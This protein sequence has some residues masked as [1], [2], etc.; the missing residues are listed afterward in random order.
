MASQE[1]KELS[2]E[3][4]KSELNAAEKIEKL[5]NN[6]SVEEI[7]DAMSMV[8]EDMMDNVESESRKEKVFL[9]V[10]QVG[11]AVGSEQMSRQGAQMYEE[12]SEGK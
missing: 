11:Q 6:Y 4:M 5:N 2:K 8:V 12:W 9:L 7:N 3:V 1:A 10:H